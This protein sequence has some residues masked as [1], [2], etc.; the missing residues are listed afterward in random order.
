MSQFPG[1]LFPSE[2]E[3]ESESPAVPSWA[4]PRV[5]PPFGTSR[6]EG[7]EVG[8]PHASSRWRERRRAYLAPAEFVGNGSVLGPVPVALLAATLRETGGHHDALNPL[9]PNHAPS[10]VRMRQWAREE[11]MGEGGREERRKGG[12]E[13]VSESRSRPS[14]AFTDTG[15]ASSEVQ[16]NRRDPCSSYSA[17]EAAAAH[18]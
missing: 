1:W 11:T 10:V 7:K 2:S 3:S 9:F 5:S 8:V 13:R 15:G 18:Q 12:K 17:V 6:S 4:A 14:G 16:S